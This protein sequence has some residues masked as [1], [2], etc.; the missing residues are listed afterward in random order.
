[1]D[2]LN[3]ILLA[4]IPA[5]IVAGTAYFVLKN[6]LEKELLRHRQELKLKRHKDVFP[7]QLE[8]YQRLTLFLERINP[9]SLV[10]RTHKAGM[11]AKA[12]QK[13]LLDAIR[14]EFEHNLAQQ[15]FV[16]ESAWELVKRSKEEVIKMINIAG[17]TIDDAATSFDL[18]KKIF[19]MLA[20]LGESPTDIAGKGLREEFKSITK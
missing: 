17:S 9:N 10:M 1:M 4:A 15:L 13:E 6:S 12:L 16:S 19:E 2:I 8:A 20:E 3:N 11:P 14:Q 5:V 7:H 18:S